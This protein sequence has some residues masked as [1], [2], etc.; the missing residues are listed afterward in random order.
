MKN[1][2][3]I[4]FFGTPDFAV[5]SLKA[6]LESGY[7]V[8]AVVTA[9][10]K[11]SGRGLKPGMSAVK[12]FA[13]L[14]KLPL[15]QPVNLKHE[16]FL[17]ELEAFHPDLQ[18]VI[19]FR[20]LPREV[21]SLPPLGTFNLH[22]SLLP[23]YRGAAPIHHAIINGEQKTGVTTFF[24]NEEIDAGKI[25]AFRE[26]TI[27]E[28]ETTGE[29]HDRLMI[30]GAELVIATTE[31]IDT[32]NFSPVSQANLLPAETEIK[33]APKI[34]RSD[35]IIDCSQPVRKIHDFIRGMSPY[36][37]ANIQ[38]RG[39]D[40]NHYDVKILRTAKASPVFYPVS[41]IITRKGNSDLFLRGNDGL[42]RVL[43]L[44]LSGR[45]VMDFREF[46]RG[47]AHIIPI[48]E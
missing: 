36:P 22:A 14:N 27:G 41:G 12:K 13:L 7:P 38:F 44:Q 25:L 24:I 2:P 5:A 43:E 48:I 40:G 39:A 3:R 37:G 16:S 46:L 15:L 28:N 33:K 31:M 29:L 9:P 10:D 34:T 35:C 30:S 42:L 45:K 47:Y 1:S 6:L 11:P 21:W 8:V 26:T 4:V 32:G 20:M 18:I 17:A 23:Q 19:A